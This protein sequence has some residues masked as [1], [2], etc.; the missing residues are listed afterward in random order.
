MGGRMGKVNW[1]SDK[2]EARTL[3]YRNMPACM[4]APWIGSLAE[5]RCHDVKARTLDEFFG[6]YERIRGNI[7][8]IPRP[9]CGRNVMK[10]SRLSRVY[11]IAFYGQ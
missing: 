3:L 1:F 6:L 11:P 9:V 5:V 8:T 2:L 4:I 10:L 7:S